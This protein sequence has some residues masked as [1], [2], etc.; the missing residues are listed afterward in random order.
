MRPPPDYLLRELPHAKGPRVSSRCTLYMQNVLGYT[1]I[2]TGLAYLPLCIV[3]GICAGI[4]SQ[5]LAQVGTRPM[6]VVGALISAGGLYWLSR[7]PSTGP[8]S[9]ISS[10]ACW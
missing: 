9:R 4:A 6:I 3:I 8:T 10:R 1:P 2:Q 5:L 7:I